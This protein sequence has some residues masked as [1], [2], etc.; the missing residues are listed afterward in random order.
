MGVFELVIL[1]LT[2]TP[3]EQA[4]FAAVLLFRLIYFILPLLAAAA[5]L[6]VY[7][8]RQSRNTLREAGR[9]LSV[10]SHSI[11]AYTTFVGG[12]ILLVSAMLPTLPAVVAQ[13]DDFLPRTLLMGGHLVCALSGALLLFVAY[14]LERRQNRAFWMAV[15][16]LLLG[17]A[18]ALLKGL[19]FLAAGAALVVLITVW[20]SR[21]RFYRSSFFWLW[22]WP[23][24]WAGSSTIR[25][26]TGPPCGALSSTSTLR[27]YCWPM[28]ASRSWSWCRGSSGSACGP[29]SACRNAICNPGVS[30]A[31]E[32]KM[33]LRAVPHG[34]AFFVGGAEESLSSS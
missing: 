14:G 1:H 15:I 30:R 31:P 13:L 6:A 25:H 8:A 17:I 9:W 4:V 23:W 18:G 7:E 34:A 10:L 3:R 24:A 11:A 22:A 27:A 26:G 16:L 29:A 33:Y 5:L 28:W 20:L 19:S 2:H 32:V 21:R 12:C